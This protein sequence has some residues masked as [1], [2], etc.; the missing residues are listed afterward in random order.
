MVDDI[1]VLI[2]MDLFTNDFFNSLL[3]DK[4]TDN[5]HGNGFCVKQHSE[6]IYDN[7]SSLHSAI[8]NMIGS[9]RSGK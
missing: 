3:N 5:F 9:L 1:F 6:A 2:K 7:A 8:N 4:K